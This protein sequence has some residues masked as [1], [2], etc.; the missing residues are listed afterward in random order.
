MENILVIYDSGYGATADVAKSIAENLANEG[1]NADLSHVSLKNPD[2]YDAAVLGSPI[3]LS[4]CTPK[5][6]TYIQRNHTALVSM[7]EYFIPQKIPH[8][9]EFKAG[10][11][12]I[13][14]FGGKRAERA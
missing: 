3:R 5:I 7:D 1:F 12:T 6:K 9:G 14:Y 10:T 2:G 4:R 13:H 8:A 11:R